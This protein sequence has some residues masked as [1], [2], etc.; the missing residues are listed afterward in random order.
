MNNIS[1][2]KILLSIFV[3]ILLIACEKDD[4]DTGY[5]IDLK[6]TPD[7]YESVNEKGQLEI[8]IKITC[9]KGLKRAFYKI[10]TKAVDSEKLTI[11]S[12]INIPVSGNTLDTT[13]VIPITMTLNSVVIAVF[14]NDDIINLR[15]VKVESVKESPVLTFKGGIK[16]RKTVAIGIPFNINGNVVS[17]HELKLISFETVNNGQKGTPVSLALGDKKNVDFTA[18]VPVAAGLQYVLLKAENIYGGIAVDTF[19]VTNVVSGDFISLTMEQNLTELN[20]FFDQEDNEL[21]G[22][23]A[24]GSDIKTLKYAVTK[25]GTEGALQTVNI[26]SDAGND[27]NFSF[28]VKGEQGIQGIRL[29]AENNGAK[30]V[31]VNLTIPAIA[32][33]ATYLQDVAMSTDPADNKCFFS[34]YRTPHVYG[35]AEGK[36]NQLMIDWVLTK[37]SSGVQPISLHAYGAST[38][39]YA[40]ALPYLGGFTDLTYLYLSSLRATMTQ[41][42]F[43]T[44]LSVK[45]IKTYVDRYIFGPAPEGQA[46]NIYTSSRRVGDTF[47]ASKTKGGFVIAWGSHTHPT[48]SPAVVNNVSHAIVWV[49]QVTQKSNGHWDIVF[50]IKFPKDDQRTPNNGSA[51][52]PYSPYPL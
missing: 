36:T 18:S 30:T 37:T 28:K 5:A 21:K 48:V 17:E 34:A 41:A 12:E 35:L 19:K 27:Y 7:V 8:P 47:S 22:N 32:I 45:D 1:F 3:G 11:G 52:A 15:T 40:N 10:V 51:I 20:Y 49:K 4:L 42:N 46:Y 25:N 33:R 24:S 43:N 16:V 14:D 26:G 6:G 44:V 31:T 39:Y 13:L 2:L 38:T 9:E 23:I 50:D 29:V